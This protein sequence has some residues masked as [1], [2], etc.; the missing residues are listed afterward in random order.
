MSAP[1]PLLAMRGIGKRFGAVQ[2]NRNVDLTL[3]PG[4]ILGLISDGIYEYE[5]EAG[6]QFGQAGIR[7]VVDENQ[8]AA[9]QVL[10]D[11]M[12]GA[13]YAHGGNVPQADDITIVLI[14]RQA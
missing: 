9:M 7:R 5:N 3:Q 1:T 4:D 11:R 13:T 2:A 10:V 8:G 6:E 12:M 14:E